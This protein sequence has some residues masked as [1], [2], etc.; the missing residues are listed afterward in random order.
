MEGWSIG[1][2]G[3]FVSLASYFAKSNVG[4]LISG[5]YLR[6]GEEGE[7]IG[8]SVVPAVAEAEA[9]GIGLLIMCSDGQRWLL[10]GLI[11]IV[12]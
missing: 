11:S 3:I 7:D 5:R 12:V 6:E 4:I 9:R 1:G 2:A 10:P 8:E